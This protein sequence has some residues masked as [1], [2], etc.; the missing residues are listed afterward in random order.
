MD[1]RTRQAQRRAHCRFPLLLGKAV[2]DLRKRQF[3]AQGGEVSALIEIYS[4]QTGNA[5]EHD[6]VADLLAVGRAQH[7]FAAQ[8]LTDR[9]LCAG[10]H[11][12][13]GEGK[14]LFPNGTD[15]GDLFHLAQRFDLVSLLLLYAAA[16]AQRR[17]YVRCERQFHIHARE[18]LARV[19]HA[20]LA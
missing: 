8:Q 7:A 14:I 10:E 16:Y 2:E 12:L 9:L 11:H 18:D 15:H 19:E 17:R 20:H 5:L 4:V 6:L 13:I 3:A 1:L